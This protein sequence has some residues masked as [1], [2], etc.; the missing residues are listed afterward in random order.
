MNRAALTQAI[1]P[2]V[3]F[4]AASALA[5]LLAGIIAPRL[6]NARDTTLLVIALV[7]YLLAV[8]AFVWGLAALIGGLRRYL[9]RTNGG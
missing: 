5:F 3:R 7:L 1:R 4:L 9:L 6:V 8:V 2:I